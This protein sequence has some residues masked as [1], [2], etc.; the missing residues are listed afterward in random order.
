MSAPIWKKI[1]RP[2]KELL[3]KLLCIIPEMRPSAKEVLEHPWV[4]KTDWEQHSE[5]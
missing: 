2:A 3:C 4:K 5:E 1:S